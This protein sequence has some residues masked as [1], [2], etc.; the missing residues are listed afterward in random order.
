MTLPSTSLP[1]FDEMTDSQKM[2]VISLAVNS[3]QGSVDRHNKI[4]VTGNGEI[5]LVEQVR[6]LREFV[7]GIKF[8]AKTAAVAIL[9]QTIAFG[10]AVVVGYIRFLPVLEK[11]ANQSP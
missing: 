8:W 2:L 6:N 3:L 7:N 9:L 5:P 10:S 11:L 4:L 1:A